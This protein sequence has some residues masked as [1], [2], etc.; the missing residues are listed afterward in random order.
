[1]INN[2]PIYFIASARDYHA[3]DWFKSIKKLNPG[4]DVL[5]ISEIIEGENYTKIINDEDVILVCKLDKFLFAKQSKMGSMW[6]NFL[7]LLITP[8][9]ILKIRNIYNKNQAAIFHAHSMYYIFICWLSGIEF[10]ATPM[11]S[12]VLVRPS[13]SRLYKFF[14]SIALIKASKITVDSYDLFWKIKELAN[15]ES[16]IIQNGI[17]CFATGPYREDINHRTRC[18]SARAIDFNYR[19]KDLVFSRNKSIPELC[20]DFIYPYYE[21]SYLQE[22][23]S[24][25]KPKDNDLGRLSKDKMYQLLSESYLVVS[26]PKS[27]SSPRTVYE[28]IFCG[29]CVAVTYNSWID[30]LPECMKHR[31]IIVDILLSILFITSI[32]H[33]SNF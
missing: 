11:G 27:D 20:L 31:L 33:G 9:F 28:A 25:L 1:M 30:S 7:K 12:D 22:L 10:I 29:A 6:R 2:N 4:R 13:N 3:V 23:R 14:T 18:V 15:R 5:I 16:H 17:D 8:L 26:I 19:V 24:L 32:C 21:N